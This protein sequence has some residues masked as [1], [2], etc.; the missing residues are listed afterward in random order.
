MSPSRSVHHR[1]RR[2]LVAGLL[3]VGL[4]AAGS[5]T[6]PA[7]PAAQAAPAGTPHLP[8]LR[9][10]LPLDSFSIVNGSGGRELRYT[11]QIYNAGAG[12]LDIAPFYSS[13]AGTYLGHQQVMTHDSAGN[14]SVLSTHRVA[15]QFKYHAEHGHFHFPLA[16]F[17][18]YKVT[19]G[20]G[21]GAP[22]TMSPK[23]GFCI[24]DSGINPDPVE[25]NG[26]GHGWWG[27]CS[28][29]T[30]LRGISVGG[31]D[32]Y[33]YR[34]PGQSVPIAGVP[35]G[36]YW[37]R[38]ISDPNNDF[39][40]SN[41]RNNEEMVRLTI[42]G[43]A[44]TVGEVR[45][46]DTAPCTVSLL[47]PTD[48]STRGGP[49]RL[50]ARTNAGAGAVVRYLVDGTT[51]AGSR[52]AS[53]AFAV[54]WSSTS[55][56][57]G[58]HWLAA[59][60]TRANGRRCTSPVVAL[61]VRQTGGTG[62]VA[63]LIRFTDPEPGSR[64]GGRVAIAVSAADPDGVARVTFAVDGHRIG[65]VR[66][67]PP[68][69]MI[70]N[71]RHVAPGRHRISARAVDT[72]GHAS[73]R[74]L[75]VRVRRVPP[76]RNVR[77]DGSVV[78]HGRDALITPG[79]STSARGA[80]V[81][82]L[83][84][85]DG[86]SAPGEQSARVTGGGLTW[87]LVKRSDSQ[88]GVSEIWAA[89]ATRRLHAAR[90][91]AAPRATGYDGMLSVFAFRNARGVGVASAAG[92][93]SGAPSFYV[94][95]VREGSWVFAAGNDWDGAV[96]RHPIPSQ[97]VRRQWIDTAAGDTFWVQSL[98]RPTTNQRLVTIRDT[99]PVADRWNYVGAEVTALPRR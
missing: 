21:V 78:A 30:T 2:A 66:H 55:V 12:P 58:G 83:V 18:L 3:L 14:W 74:S 61:Q 68:F 6:R 23:V 73:T 32:E 85:Y 69:S 87:R 29:P 98:K 33:D 11:H 24:G 89:R 26:V 84:S 10:I 17:G 81:L 7:V 99:A 22:V 9:T 16:T 37:F 5:L 50:T 31:Y 63:P 59:Q 53:S 43:D 49:V 86:P 75:H 82:A 52:S 70:W 88:A 62:S 27:N 36:T 94:P 39:V 67:H 93:P 28:D 91:T 95:A 19:A 13:S 64:V 46:P 96:A 72:R 15:D 65:K 25:H 71:S 92:Q 20:G 41:E 51:V 54:R 38:A 42:S 80:V 48:G 90:V 77:I 76:P 57:N 35:N 1:L 8:D 44:V 60:A 40:E 97:T 4:L 34:D 47:S 79:L 45:Y 56:V